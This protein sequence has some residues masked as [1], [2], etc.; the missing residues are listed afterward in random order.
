MSPVSF[1]APGDI[2]ESRL[3]VEVEVEGEVEVEEGTA[4]ETSGSGAELLEVAAHTRN[5]CL[6]ESKDSEQL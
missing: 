3:E 1:T 6:Q 4:V 2:L 5:C